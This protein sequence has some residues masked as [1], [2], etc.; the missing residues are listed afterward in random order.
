MSEVVLGIDYGQRKIGLAI[1]V[2]SVASPYTILEN[3]DSLLPEI[4]TIVKDENIGRIVVGLPVSFQ[5]QDTESTKQAEDFI[6]ELATTV[7]VPVES[8]DETL[9][10]KQAQRLGAG[11]KDDATAA[12]LLLQTYLDS[13]V[14][15]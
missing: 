8:V 2:G 1:G 11:S 15:H 4:E 7:S 10:S 13:H 12:A 14:S 6:Q 5:K 9:T 3:T